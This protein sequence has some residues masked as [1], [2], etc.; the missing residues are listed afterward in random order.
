M[1]GASQK[2]FR[3]PPIVEINRLTFNGKLVLKNFT[4]V[5]AARSL[6]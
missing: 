6:G 2:A 1:H 3:T 4:I 5:R